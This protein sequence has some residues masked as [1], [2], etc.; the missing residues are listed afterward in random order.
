M[1]RQLLSMFAAA[2]AMVMLCTPANAF[3]WTFDD[4]LDGLQETPPNSSPAT[5]RAMGTYND[6]TNV[7]HIMVH[8]SGFVGNI[9]AGHIHRAATGSAGPI[10]FFL[11]NTGGSSMWM[12]DNTFNLTEAQETDLMNGLYYVNLHTNVFPGGEIRGQLHLVPEPASLL[13]LAGGLGVLLRR[14]RK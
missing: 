1:K 2:A 10:V 12:S 3:I 11:T 9:T 4:P 7:L 8:A 13:A 14:R 6:E 5:G